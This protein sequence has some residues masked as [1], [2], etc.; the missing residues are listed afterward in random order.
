MSDLFSEALASP[1]FSPMSADTV[2]E[3][4]I[5]SNTKRAVRNN[6]H[7]HK[8]DDISSLHR[9]SLTVLLNREVYRDNHLDN[10]NWFRYRAFGSC[11]YAGSRSCGVYNHYGDWYRRGVGRIIY[12]TGLG[13][14][15]ARRACWSNYVRAGGDS[16]IGRI[17]VSSTNDIH[18]S[19][20]GS[21]PRSRSLTRL[22][23]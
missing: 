13:L 1:S 17:S 20:I 9:V 6:F 22:I 19:V 21:E 12:W 2:M 15:R 4:Q 16:A 7:F 11:S 14:L 8:S 23:S 3:R 18:G 10:C 5:S